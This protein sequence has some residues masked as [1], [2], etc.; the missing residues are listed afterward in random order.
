VE[1]LDEDVIKYYTNYLEGVEPIGLP[2]YRYEGR[3]RGV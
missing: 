1:K 3:L 2:K